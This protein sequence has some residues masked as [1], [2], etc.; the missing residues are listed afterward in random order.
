M[1]R[2]PEAER[3]EDDRRAESIPLYEQI[4]RHVREQIASGT[5]RVGDRL[6]SE[7]QLAASFKMAR[8]TVHRALRELAQE[9][10]IR[11]MHGL[12]S[13][14]APTRITSP[15]VRI[16]N[17]ADEVRGRGQ[18]F[19]ATV[20]RLETVAATGEI[21]DAME[22]AEGTPLFHSAIVYH[23][24]DAPVQL[25]DR[26]VKPSFAPSYIEQDFTIQST[27]DY[28]QAITP[29]TA[30]EHVIEAVMPDPRMRKL[31]SFD[32]GEAC[33][34]VSRKT[35]VGDAVTTFTRFMHP[36]TRRR[37]ISRVSAAHGGETGGPS[38]A[39]LVEF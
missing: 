6:P 7:N 11:R 17:I 24:D 19:G 29:A 36:G 15:I 30:A 32:K 34:I 3:R 39:Q 25:E 8:L 10:V 22:V 26:F 27:T 38:G 4:K 14:V 28:L 33:L 13:V 5:L 31:L 1:T 2:E 20:M 37:L 35:W 12:G 18:R 23:A 16:H 21:A 9:G